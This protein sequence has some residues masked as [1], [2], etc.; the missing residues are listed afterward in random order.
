MANEESTIKATCPSCGD[1]ELTRQQVRLV[2]CS[3]KSWSYYAFTC[4]TCQNEVRKPARPGAVALLISAGVIAEHW[5]VPAEAL[6]THIGPAIS[7]DEVL[8]FTLWLEQADMLA[9]AAG[10]YGRVS[11]IKLPNNDS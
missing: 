1:V 5:H 3:V 7:S 6:E 2:V 10:Q 4:A 11:D 8:D 9:A